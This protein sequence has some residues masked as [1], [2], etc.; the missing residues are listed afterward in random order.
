MSTPVGRYRRA[1]TFFTAV[2]TAVPEDQPDAPTPCPAWTV[3]QLIGHVIDGQH[4]VISLLRG[5]GPSLPTTD[6]AQLA[7]LAEPDP[8]AA[9]L[10]T[11]TA[12]EAGLADLD[13]STALDTPLGVRT[14][15]D[16]LAL[17]I[18]EPLAH[19]WD[20][21]TATGQDVRFDPDIVEVVR[22]AVEAL[23][24]QLAATG[25]YAPAVPVPADASAQDRLLAVLGRRPR[26]AD[27]SPTSAQQVT[28]APR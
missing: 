9:W 13:P 10:R 27:Q 8:V 14:G 22:P 6:P 7:A 2:A 15:A 26:R 3:R 16:I 1:L 11:R 12:V 4:Q 21:A 24:D 18:I 19:A 5:Q 17:A 23:G 25:M 28:E 20:L